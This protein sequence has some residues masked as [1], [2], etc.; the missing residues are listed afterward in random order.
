MSVFISQ[1][2]TAI[3]TKNDRH[4]DNDV[5]YRTGEI[6]SLHVPSLTLVAR[7]EAC[8]THAAFMNEV[9]AARS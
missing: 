5:D 2:A 6:L 4:E 7:H 8:V 3:N 1:C 9:K